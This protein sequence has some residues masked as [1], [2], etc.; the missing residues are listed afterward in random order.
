MDKEKV[1]R[2]FIKRV[3]EYVLELITDAKRHRKDWERGLP[4]LSNY[5]EKITG[6]RMGYEEIRD[7]ARELWENVF[8]TRGEDRILLENPYTDKRF[9]VIGEEIVDGNSEEE[10]WD[11]VRDFMGLYDKVYLNAGKQG[12]YV[13]KEATPEK[14]NIYKIVG[15]AERDDINSALDIFHARNI[16]IKI[17]DRDRNVEF[18][19]IKSSKDHIKVHLFQHG[20]AWVIMDINKILTYFDGDKEQL[21]SYFE[22]ISKTLHEIMKENPL[23]TER[24]VS[25][26]IPFEGGIKFDEKWAES[27]VIRIEDYIKANPLSPREYLMASV[28]EGLRP[29][30]P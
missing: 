27:V 28:I 17:K 16:E 7:F 5:I 29:F 9:I 2:E 10:K 14:I 12:I 4:A 24:Y 23:G 21:G 3:P 8:I 13:V 6:E 11:K 30:T 15:Y 26:I 19:G 20:L 1:K 25:I 22:Y 18:I